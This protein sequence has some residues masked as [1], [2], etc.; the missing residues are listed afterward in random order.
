MSAHVLHFMSPLALP[1]FSPS[2][3]SASLRRLGGG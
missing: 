1:A 3:V 2:G